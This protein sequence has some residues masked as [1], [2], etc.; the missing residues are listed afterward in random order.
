MVTTRARV[1]LEGDGIVFRGFD[2]QGRSIVLDSGDDAI[3]PSPV[4]ALLL[5]LGACSGMDVIG[6]LR[7]QRQKVTAYEILLD[8][9]RRD[10]FPRSFTAIEVVHR[11]TGTAV[12]PRA[13]AEAIRLSDTKYCSVHA[14]LVPGVKITSRFEILAPGDARE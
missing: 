4:V 14:T 12:D 5:A 13:L 2:E 6:I 8:G 9:T 11:V 7:K 10:E 3:A 1:A